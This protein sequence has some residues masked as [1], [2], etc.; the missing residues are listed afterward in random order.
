MAWDFENQEQTKKEFAKNELRIRTLIEKCGGD[1]EKEIAKALRDANKITTPEK[2]YN[3][4][5][6]AKQL[7]LPHVF[8]V[9]YNRAY[10]LGKVKDGKIVGVGVAEH[11][12]H[13][14][15]KILGGDD[16]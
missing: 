11:R 2:A 8:E 12:E 4:G 10:E 7:G 5:F 13:I 3:R 6:V 9:F 1:K 15:D 14:I 16:E